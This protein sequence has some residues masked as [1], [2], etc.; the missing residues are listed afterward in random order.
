MATTTEPLPRLLLSITEAAAMVGLS[1]KTQ[2]PPEPE[3]SGAPATTTKPSRGT[4]NT[5]EPTE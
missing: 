5:K 3:H 2:P 1:T 4:T